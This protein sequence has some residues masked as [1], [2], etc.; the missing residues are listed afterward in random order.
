VKR[1][2]RRSA[3]SAGYRVSDRDVLQFGIEYM[4]DI[5]RLGRAWNIPIRTFFDIGAANCRVAIHSSKR[6]A[7]AD[8]FA[9]NNALRHHL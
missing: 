9:A 1:V 6:S 2:F 3:E 8:R 7:R 5:V 4:L